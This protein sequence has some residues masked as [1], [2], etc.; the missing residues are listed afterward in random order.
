MSLIVRFIAPNQTHSD[1]LRTQTLFILKGSFL[2]FLHR[3]YPATWPSTCI[4]LPI[5]QR[6][7]H[8]SLCSGSFYNGRSKLKSSEFWSVTVRL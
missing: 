6:S 3:N 2:L 7:L 1:S 4:L 8:S 5:S